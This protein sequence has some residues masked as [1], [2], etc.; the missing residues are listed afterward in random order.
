MEC[1][2]KECLNEAKMYQNEQKCTNNFKFRKCPDCNFINSI[3]PT[4]EELEI[5]QNKC[6][7]CSKFFCM[8]SA[9]D[10]YKNL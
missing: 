10:N 4:T 2:L 1:V 8:K 3:R 6:N 5:D 9:N 7:A